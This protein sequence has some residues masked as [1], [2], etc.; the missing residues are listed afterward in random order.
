MK[1]KVQLSGYK[2]V[3]FASTWTKAIGKQNWR[4]GNKCS[5]CSSNQSHR[6]TFVYFILP[7]T[8]SN[9]L[10]HPSIVLHLH[11]QM[12]EW[13]GVILR[14]PLL[15]L[16]QFS[17]TITVADASFW[18]ATITN[19]NLWYKGRERTR[20]S[21]VSLSKFLHSSISF[22]IYNCVY[23]DLLLSSWICFFESNDIALVFIKNVRFASTF[24]CRRRTP[25]QIILVNFQST[26]CHKWQR[27]EMD[28]DLDTTKRYLRRIVRD[29]P[30]R[31]ADMQKGGD[32]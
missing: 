24:L 28:L 21:L 4:W 7:W 8:N 31:T 30:L 16:Q 29:E 23:T 12:S 3:C 25:K 20:I 15:L 17:L 22:C 27:N 26:H 18:K 32:K 13:V 14:L 2:N 1:I 6:A 19:T 5:D 10:V 11:L 9:E